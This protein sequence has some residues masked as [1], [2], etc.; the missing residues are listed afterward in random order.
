VA[1]E[2]GVF[3]F[4]LTTNGRAAHAAQPWLGDDAIMAMHEC[5][6]RLAPLAQAS[7]LD[8]MTLVVPT[9]RGGDKNNVVASSCTAEVDV[10]FPAPLTPDDVHA[11]M[12]ERLSG[13][14]VR[15][16][17]ESVLEAFSSD[18]SSALMA[19]L[20]SF[21]SEKPS[22]VPFATEAPKFAA[23]NRTV[24][25]CGPGE[26]GQAHV[27]DEHVPVADLER[28]YDMVMHLARKAPGLRAVKGRR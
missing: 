24:I 17:P 14:N 25:I 15:L 19:E 3:R 9:V 6:S 20:S 1:R 28:A 7:S 27:L 12:L 26:P 21:L 18:P 23:Y 5:V 16:E 10:R 13:I 11:M 4:R 2:K 8:G 22:D